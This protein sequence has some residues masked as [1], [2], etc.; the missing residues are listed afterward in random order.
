MTLHAALAAAATL[1]ALAFALSTLE[2]W[3]GRRRRH[4]AV[5]TVSL[6]MFSLASLALWIGAAVGWHAWSFKLFYLFGAILNVP[7]L[8][9]GTVYLLAGQ[10]TGDRWT[11]AVTVLGA[12]AAG[13]V[14]AAP[15]T[16]AIEPDVLP[17]GSEVFGAGPRI[18]AAVSSGVA[19]IVIIGGAVWSAWR[20]LRQDG[21]P[22][23]GAVP[24]LSPGRLA[25]ANLVIAAGTLILSAGG[26]LNSVLDAMDGFA[27]SLV[28]G[29]TVIFVGFLLTTSPTPLPP[30]QP[31]YPPDA[32]TAQAGS[33]GAEPQ[34]M[35]AAET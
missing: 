24:S 20:L 28:V 35:G 9:L 8:A 19:A 17:R 29:I 3:L 18:A 4:E 11:A 32:V 21:G 15:L 5:W 30:P 1:V 16:A 22:A 31:W 33:A 23:K 26:V 14:V 10:R 27:V 7:F 34:P 12:F 25:L 2:R 6:L 13:L